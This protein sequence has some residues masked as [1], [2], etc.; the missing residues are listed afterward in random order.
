MC[1]RIKN[2]ILR[3]RIIN[4][5]L[6]H[7]S[8]LYNRIGGL[9]HADALRGLCTYH[10]T[11]GI[12]HITTLGKLHVTNISQPGVTQRS[13]YIGRLDIHHITGLDLTFVE[14]RW[15]QDK[16]GVQLKYRHAYGFCILVILLDELKCYTVVRHVGEL[17]HDNRICENTELLLEC[18]LRILCCL[19]VHSL[20]NNE[21]SH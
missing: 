17:V 2:I 10:S 14:E 13:E 21:F 6:Q 5:G 12:N 11:S 18:R 1:C 16:L 9:F 8:R 3:Y 7:R 4:H 19:L 15:Y 20:L